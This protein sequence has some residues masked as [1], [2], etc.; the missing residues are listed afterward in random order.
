MA[1]FAERDTKSESEGSSGETPARN[2]S[3]RA[4]LVQ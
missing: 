4:V 2:R 1:T 3:P